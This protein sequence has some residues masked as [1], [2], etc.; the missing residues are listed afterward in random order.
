MGGANAHI[1]LDDAYHFLKE[2]RLSGFHHCDIGSTGHAVGIVDS[3]TATNGYVDYKAAAN[4]ISVGQPP[5]RLLIWSAADVGA[6]TRMSQAY[7]NYYQAQVGNDHRKLDQLAY[8]LVR[9]RST[10]PWRT[11]AVAGG[12]DV[13]SGR[14]PLTFAPPVRA[15]P[16]KASI[17]LIFTGQGA[18]YA[19]MGLQLLQFPVFES[20][21]Q[22][23]NVIFA[24]LGAEWSV[25]GECED[26]RA[27]FSSIAQP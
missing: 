17:G 5:P 13:N 16:E 26:P 1:I 15:S 19:E 7:Q 8:T 10:M 24:D 6:I 2:H 20:S 9:R 12:V 14:S 4:G 18:Q 23:S 22:L 3:H 25:L 27:F 21:L 11:F